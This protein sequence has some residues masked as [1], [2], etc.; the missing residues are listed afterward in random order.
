MEYRRGRGKREA[1]S[2]EGTEKSEDGDKR[3]IRFALYTVPIPRSHDYLL[4]FIW[5]PTFPYSSFLGLSGAAQLCR[6]ILER[7]RIRVKG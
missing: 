7:S 4:I 2:C 6:S 5:L 3:R 1:G